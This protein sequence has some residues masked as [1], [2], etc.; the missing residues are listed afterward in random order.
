MICPGVAHYS[1][2][3]KYGAKWHTD[4][5]VIPEL[6]LYA[7]GDL[8]AQCGSKALSQDDH[9]R[10]AIKLLLPPSTGFEWH[11]WAN[12]II[13]EWCATDI[14]ALWGPSSSGKSSI[15]G[16]ITYVDLLADPENTLVVMVTNPLKMHIERSWGNLLTWRSKMPEHWKVG[17]VLNPQSPRLDTSN[18][19]KFTGVRCIS[20]ED[21]ETEKSLKEKIGGHAKRNRLIVD[22][23]QGC[24]DIVLRIKDN[25][26]ASGEYK[27]AHAGNPDSWMN[28][29]GEI[30]EPHG[31]TRKQV[32]EE[33]PD[34][35]QT[36]QGRYRA[37]GSFSRG[38]CL[39]L[40]GEKCPTMDSAEEAK[41]LFFLTQPSAIRTAKEVP[42]AENSAYYWTYIRGRI[43]PAGG[44]LT[45]LS[46]LD[47]EASGATGPRPWAARAKR[48]RWASFDLSLGGDAIPGTLF[49]VGEVQVGV[50]PG[51]PNSAAPGQA[52]PVIARIVEQQ[53]VSVSVKEADASGQVAKGIIKQ[54]EQWG[55]KSRDDWRR[56]AM[57]ASG[58]Q[59]AIVDTVE[60]M[61]TEKHGTSFH[62]C[63]VRV[64]WEDKVSERRIGPKGE[65]ARDRIKT[66]AA[67]LLIQF[68]HLI[69]DHQVCGIPKDVAYQLTS[70][71]QVEQDGKSDIEPKPEWRR[72]HKGKSPD[73]L[74]SAAIG[75][76]AMLR[77]G[78]LKII[79]R[80][81]AAVRPLEL[82]PFMMPKKR[83]SG[84]MER[85][86]RV[87]LACR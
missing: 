5:P 55:M 49:E 62:G 80:R 27:E 46:E 63:I 47:L 26:G 31:I 56:V 79:S 25:L 45:V 22:E 4:D 3:R 72:A 75:I 32:M 48:E 77:H 53:Y 84:T 2:L 60:R 21:G 11:R 44:R 57:D 23:S 42:G 87:S 59:G 82:E 69:R 43:P 1:M 14:M 67:E 8:R 33:F 71:G 41:R 20:T 68:A 12:S 78:I 61:L 19:G 24:K 13:D 29:L 38:V 76:E 70:R 6:R 7:D 65:V 74:D 50:V 9:L 18:G 37:D 51:Q 52:G 15:L 36:A 16:L 66:K 17:R 54:V 58:Q 10:N 40:D 39:V 73:E 81:F 28:P 83:D 64:K 85:R 30:S 86:R 34:R 35:W